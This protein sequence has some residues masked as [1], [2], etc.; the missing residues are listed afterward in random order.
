MILPSY[1]FTCL[2]PYDHLYCIP[3]IKISTGLFG[4]TRMTLIIGTHFLPKLS[5]VLNIYNMGA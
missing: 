1:A 5:R 2:V 4:E 3:Y